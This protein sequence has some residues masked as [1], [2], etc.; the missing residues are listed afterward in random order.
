MIGFPTVPI[1]MNMATFCR[2]ARS[3]KAASRPVWPAWTTESTVTLSRFAFSM[4]RSAAN[5]AVTCPKAQFPLTRALVALSSSTRG[6]A[7]ATIS[8]ARTL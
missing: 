1:A 7:V 3:V 2:A 8:P 6:R 5:N 4:A